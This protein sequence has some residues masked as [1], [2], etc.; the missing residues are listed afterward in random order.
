[1]GFPPMFKH[2]LEAD[3]TTK[4]SPPLAVRRSHLT[5]KLKFI[6]AF[7]RAFRHRTQRIFRNMDRQ[8]CFFAQKFIETTQE[9]AAARQHQSA[10]DQIG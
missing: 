6:E 2:R 4:F 5:Q 10:I 8:T 1:M 7:A 9:R 3:A